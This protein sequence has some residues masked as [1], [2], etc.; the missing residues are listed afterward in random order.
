MYNQLSREQRYAIYLGLESKESKK[1][2]ARK[3]RV[4]PSTIT[5]ELKRNMTKRGVY[6]WNKAH[7]MAS[8]RR[9]GKPGNRRLCLTLVLRI[10]D[11]IKSEQWSPKQ[12]SGY[13][14][15]EGIKVSHEA[16]YRIIRRDKTGEL[17]KHTRHGMRYKRR[18]KPLKPTK[19]TNI[20]NRISIHERPIE[21]DGSR[22]GDWEMDLIIGKDGKG[23]ILTMVERSTNFL[24]MEKLKNGKNAE[25]LAKVVVRLLFAYRGKGLKTITTDNG[26]EFAAHEKITKGLKGVAVYFA[27]SYAS[28]Q[29]GAIENTNKLIRQYIP[30]GVSFD[31]VSN[32]K[33]Q[34]IQ[35]KI[36]ARP[37][38]K[39]NFDTPKR[40]F[41]KLVS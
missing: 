24:I 34:L 28:W 11:L 41:F 7:D 30:K 16:I 35:R 25:E 3:L 15:L 17:A 10:K 12:I 33:I 40:R 18:Q 26:S 27:D 39:L 37:R 23:A 36:N 4:H 9:T 19:A 8:N 13:L 5:R 21:A 20:P 6:V 22:L 2:I 38:E 1:T 31:G 14:A 32:K 29:K